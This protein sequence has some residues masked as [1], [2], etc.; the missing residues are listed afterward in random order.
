MTTLAENKVRDYG[1]D[2]EEMQNDLPIIASDT[3]YEGAAVGENGVGYMRPL[4]AADPFVGFAVRKCAN[5][6]PG[7]AG[8]KLVRL[9]SKGTV[10]LTVAGV[11]SIA[12]AQDGTDV[13]ASDDDT[14]TLTASGNTKIGRLYRF[15]SSGIAWVYYES[16]STQV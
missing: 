4:V 11:T 10:K 14:F 2:F 13:Y 1:V 15:V 12:N 8:D 5:E 6:A 9:R 7:A 16:T 3:I